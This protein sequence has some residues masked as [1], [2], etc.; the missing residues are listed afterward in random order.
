MAFFETRGA[1]R[2]VT[3]RCVEYPRAG[4]LPL[5]T[6]TGRSELSLARGTSGRVDVGSSETASENVKNAF[7]Q[8]PGVT[9]SGVYPI[10]RNR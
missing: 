1:P 6:E 5:R 10:L 8:A 7:T 4:T 2:P 3:A 9:V